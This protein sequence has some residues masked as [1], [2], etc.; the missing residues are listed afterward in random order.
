VGQNPAITP[1]NIQE[2]DKDARA[3]VSVPQLKRRCRTRMKDKVASRVGRRLKWKNVI[4]Y[5]R[6]AYGSMDR[7]VELGG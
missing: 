2:P 4:I 6:C 5:G 3:E 1:K 7:S